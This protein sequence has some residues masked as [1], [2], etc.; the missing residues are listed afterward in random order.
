MVR[1]GGG[2]VFAMVAASVIG[3]QSTP[4]PIAYRGTVEVTIGGAADATAA[5]AFGTISGL[6]FA[7]DGRLVV[8]DGA[9]HQIRVFAANGAPAFTFGRRGAGPGDFTSPCCLTIDAAG[10]LWVKDEGNARYVAYRLE[11]ARAV[12]VA[13]VRGGPNVVSTPARVDF[14]SAGRLIDLQVGFVARTR[15]FVTTRVRRTLQGRPVVEDTLHLPPTD[16]LG[17]VTIPSA[18]GATSYTQ[19]FGAVAL[20]AVGAHGQVAYAVSS[21]YAVQW[22]DAAGRLVATVS[23]LGARGPA[24]SAEERQETEAW[25]ERLA[26]QLKVPRA[27]LGLTV[28]ARKAPLQGLGFDLDGRLWI[29]RTA[30]AGSEREA[31]VVVPGGR[32]HLRMT[33]PRHIDLRTLAVTGTRALGVAVDPDGAESVVVLSFRPVR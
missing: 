14:D 12:G 32:P 17:D 5:N 23:E 19:P 20:Q 3:A 10:V 2:G 9:L 27:Q 22:F 15:R 33:W 7:R 16:S 26:R 11:R 31:D 24:V 28:P 4:Q 8:A 1:W 29:E 30:A 13:T 21:R 25:L 6:A 18:T